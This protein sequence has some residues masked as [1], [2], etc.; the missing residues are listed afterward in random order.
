MA[1]DPNQILPQDSV[2]GG[3]D[4]PTD[5][6]SPAGMPGLIIPT[7]FNL[8]DPSNKEGLDKLK[9]EIIDK[10][11]HWETRMTTL[12]SEYEEYVD[13]WRIQAR[14]SANR[15]KALFNSKSGETHRAT[16]TQATFWFNQLT[17]ADPFYF[18]QGE[19]L[20]D[21]GNEVS[22]IQL[23]AVEA[24]IRKQ[25]QFIRFNEKLLRGLR[26]LSLFG[27]M[28]M[29][30]PWTSFPYGDGSKTFEGTDMILRPLL[31][32][33]FNPFVFDLDLSD[34][35]FTI[36]FPTAWMLRNWARNNTKDWDLEAIERIVKEHKSETS[37]G[38]SKTLTY[39]RVLQRK[40]RAGYTVIDNNNL[41]F[42][43]F[44]GR[45]DTEIDV[46]QKYWESEGRQDDPAMSD[47]SIGVLSEEG[48]VNFHATP[49]R[50][51]HHLFKIA[52]SKL[53]EMEPLGYGVGKIGRKRQKELDALESRTND[54]TMFNVLPMWKIGKY[55]GVDVSKL[56]IKPWS[57][58]ELEN[59]DQLEPIQ[60]NIN[61]IPYSLNMQGI[62]KE[63]F[64][65]SNQATGNLQG[66]SGADSATAS[67]IIQ[68]ESA[69]FGNVVSKIIA[70]TFLREF[71][72]TSHINNT[73]LM[74][75]GFW[76]KAMGSPKPIYVDKN[77]LPFNVGFFMKLTTDRDSRPE[78]IKSI[79]ESLQIIS[80]IRNT[81]DP[82]TAINMEKILTVKLLR[83]LGEDVRQL[84]TPVPIADQMLYQ[85]RQQ[86]NQQGPPGQGNKAESA[87]VQA[88]GGG[89]GGNNVTTPG[90]LRSPVG[91]VLTSPNPQQVSMS[92][93]Q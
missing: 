88:G 63:D 74:D 60:A 86:Q 81:F 31:T 4:T 59:I 14:K 19:G 72:Q 22:E 25:L 1:T 7:P 37:A 66:T 90:T 12:F 78:F 56:T 34:F 35:I 29:E 13:S 21:F 28:I 20:D 10:S 84:T 41:E 73:F 76:I 64:R 5:S 33:G 53:L 54:L 26:S 30:C 40:Q 32:T 24:T 48:V 43:K 68:N 8:S 52:H 69:R 16:E 39:S 55:A 23:Q 62:W 11:S 2:P 93:M 38:T 65:A 77:Y 75:N 50:S 87:G 27:T 49:F 71:L 89:A 67:A 36:D 85:M 3:A 61:A 79:L 47:F 80:S 45:V 91:P 70:E 6:L 9:E 57:F 51:W 17:Q 58:V 92:A 18:A 42:V 15:P 83:A 46:I 82:Q 44:H